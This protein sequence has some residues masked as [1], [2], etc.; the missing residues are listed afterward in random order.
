MGVQ[1]HVQSRGDDAVMLV[2]NVGQLVGEDPGVVVVDEHQHP[3]RLA[4]VHL[5]L[6]LDQLGAEQ[7]P[8]ELAPIGI[9]APDLQP[10]Q[11]PH[12]SV[13]QRH[14]E[15][16]DPSPSRAHPIGLSSPRAAMILRTPE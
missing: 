2:L 3:D 5:P 7:V 11:R 12:Q 1:V 15:P 4:L 8:D 16:A 9:A 6:L 13:R 14:R 10:V